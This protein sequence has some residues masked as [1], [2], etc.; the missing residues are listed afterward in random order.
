MITQETKP[1]KTWGG[2]NLAI[3]KVNL[4]SLSWKNR[5]SSNKTYKHPRSTSYCYSPVEPTDTTTCKLQIH[6]LLLSWI[7]HQIQAHPLVFSLNFNGNNW[8]DHQGVE[9]SS[10]W[11]PEVYVKET[12][13][14]ISQKIHINCNMSNTKMWLGFPLYTSGK[15]ET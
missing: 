7:L 2:F 14:K 5:N 13:S 6:G 12:S 9:K 8:N 15:L 10:S 11:K 1:V 3:L 4:S